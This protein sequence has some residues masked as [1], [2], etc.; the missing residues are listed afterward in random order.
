[1]KKCNKC[2]QNKNESEFNFQRNTCKKCRYEYKKNLPKANHSVSVV[3]KIC[4]KCK[5]VKSAEEFH[6]NSMYTTGLALYCKPCANQ[7]QQEKYERYKERYAKKSAER[8]ARVKGTEAINA[9]ARERQKKRMQTDPHYVLARRLR[10]RLYYAL[11]KK[12]WKKGTKFSEYIGCT[13]EELKLHLEKQF[14]PNM[15]WE[16]QGDWHIDH[17]IPLD[18]AMTE[19]ELYKLCHYTNL[20]PLWGPDNIKKGT[21]VN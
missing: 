3:E 13:L 8:Y 16:N 6:L 10:N 11:Q 20:Q 7:K 17:I 12:S 18:S 21:K 4:N 14:L 15:S 1:M 5:I 9:P 19:E 2:L